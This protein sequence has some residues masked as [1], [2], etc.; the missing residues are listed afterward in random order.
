MCS[1]YEL[2]SNIESIIAG[3]AL[4]VAPGDERSRGA[5][6]FN[7]PEIRPT[8]LAPII[9]HGRELSWRPWGLNVDWQN[10]PVINARGETLEQK[11]TFKP[12]LNRRILVPSSAYFEW[13]KA[14]RDKIK[15]RIHLAEQDLMAFAG[16]VSDDAFTVVTCAPSNSIAHIHD[17]MPVVLDLAAQDAWLSPRP[18]AEVK[19]VLQSSVQPLAFEELSPPQRQGE[20]FS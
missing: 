14:G 12:L 2:R 5:T 9:G 6:A 1:R 20:L 3:F 19:H 7:L 15:T 11:P 4:R 18:F 10:Q 13:R 16:L 17:R 8:N